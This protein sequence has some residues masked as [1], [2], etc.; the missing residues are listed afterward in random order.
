[1]CRFLRAR[2]WDFEAS[3]KMIFEAE[4]WRREFKVDELYETFTF[5]ERR[6][7]MDL[8]PQYYHKTD[9]VCPSFRYTDSVWSPHLHRTANSFRT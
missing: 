4:T 6:A 5:P 3:K 2:K 7:V 1:V 9:K 8:Y